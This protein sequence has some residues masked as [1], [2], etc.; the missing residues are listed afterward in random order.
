MIPRHERICTACNIGSIENEHH[1]LLECN[2]Y[3]LHRELENLGT[4]VSVLLCLK[5]ENIC[6]IVKLLIKLEEL[7]LICVR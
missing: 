4:T 2:S 1:F 7:C 6:N 3:K 5:I